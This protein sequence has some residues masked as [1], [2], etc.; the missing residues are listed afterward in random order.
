MYEVW[1]YSLLSVVIV[2]LLSLVGILTFS[3]KVERLK[4]ILIYMISFAAGALLGD[5]FIHL[6]PEVV[7]EHGFGINIS[8]YILSGIAVFFIGEKVI[9]WRHCHLPITSEHKHPFAIMN[10]FG[11]SVHNFVDGI[12]IGASYLVS[13]PVGL[14]TTLA[15]IIHE[16]PQ[17]IADFGVLLHGGFTKRKALFFNFLT[18]LTSIVGV[19][20]VL[21]LG[22]YVENITIFMIPFTAGGFIYIAGADLIPEMHKE[23]EISRSFFQFIAFI[24]GAAVMVLL[25][26]LEF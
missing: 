23:V 21:L 22:Q 18:A 1:F 24:S 20:L 5:V 12:I 3:M 6:L 2:S 4:K 25:L 9:H 8:M 14:A 11:D 15:V 10:L 16:I 17:E 7:N 19:V 13:I 26:F